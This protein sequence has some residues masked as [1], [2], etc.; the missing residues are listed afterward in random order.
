MA[1]FPEIPEY[2]PSGKV[3]KVAYLPTTMHRYARLKAQVKDVTLTRP[4]KYDKDA[5]DQAIELA[6][7]AVIKWNE[8]QDNEYREHRKRNGRDEWPE[9]RYYVKPE[10]ATYAE[11]DDTYYVIV[12]TRNAGPEE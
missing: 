9:H 3:V 12:T 2:V 4:F 7:E 8:K 10:F 11:A 5:R 1:Y 6:V